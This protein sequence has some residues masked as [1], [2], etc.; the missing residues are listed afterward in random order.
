[1]RRLARQLSFAGALLL[2]GPGGAAAQGLP[3]GYDQGLFQVV[4]PRVGSAVVVVL[5]NPQGDVLLP[6]APVLELAS[7]PFAADEG[8]ALFRVPGPAGSDTA[9]LD[10]TRRQ[11]TRPGAADLA[12]GP[13][14]ARMHDGEPYVATRVLRELLRAQVT[15]EW[16]H[17]QVALTRDPPFPAQR[18][19]ELELQR[20]LAEVRARGHGAELPDA[21]L[22][23]RTGGGVLSWSLS[24]RHLD[25]LKASNLFGQAGVAVLGGRAT[26]GL[27]ASTSY[28]GGTG[29]EQ[30]TAAYERVFPGERWLSR[31]AVGDVVS[32]GVVARSLRGVSLTNAP[33]TRTPQF[34][35]ILVQPDL[36][37]GWQFEVYQEGRLVGFSDPAAPA[38][39]PVALSYGTTPLEVRM[40]GP[41]GEEVVSDLLYQIPTEHLQDGQLLYAAGGGACP[42][43]RCDALGYGALDYGVTRW[44]TL[45]T[46]GEYLREDGEGALRLSARGSIAP[47]GHWMGEFQALQGSF[48]QGSVRWSGSRRASGALSAALRS[49]GF[50]QPTF[51]PGPD[52]RWDVNAS[53]RL[54]PVSGNLRVAGPRGAR[55]DQWRVGLS[56]PIPR[57]Y[58]QGAFEAIRPADP[59]LEDLDLV[60]LRTFT[61][62][63][64]RWRR[65]PTLN[66]ALRAAAEGL[67]GAELGLSM[68]LGSG[69]A[70]VNGRWQTELGASLAVSFTRSVPWGRFQGVASAS[71]DEVL[72]AG[73]TLDGGLALDPRSPGSP[74]PA[75]SFGIGF[76]GV[77]GHVF[78]D[79]DGDGRFGAG[80][81]PAA[82]IQV[83]VAGRTGRTDARGMYQ[84][85]AV[86]PYD[87]VAVSVDTVAS[88]LPTWAPSTS[89]H[90]LRPVPHVF[91]DADFPLVRTRE[92]IGEVVAGP[93][94]LTSGGVTLELVHLD[95][96]ERREVLT[97]ED[98]Q[99][100]VSRLQVGGYE[101][102]V[103]P[104]SLR[105]L[106]ARA[107]PGTV[108]FRV[109]GRGE[110]P[111]V[112][113]ETVRLE[114]A[115]AGR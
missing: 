33:F 28:A 12:L 26:V 1:M 100:Y 66:A 39:V 37:A 101:L 38:P 68:P 60:S 25:P 79:Y 23:S 57:G 71:G 50:G 6:L 14:D 84:I 3:S 48:L 41:A 8:G 99:F 109:E 73:Y 103:A 58:L 5:V 78:Y 47:Q 61:L 17:L 46:G 13:D 36:P 49:P 35:Q 113:V 70:S 11:L 24:S 111:F 83:R 27:V 114:R 52:S 85:W 45:G 104:A 105:A 96:G 92:L 2:A 29:L 91:N 9:L 4:I 40:Y 54:S 62:L 19:A 53:G 21:P 82:D 20:R 31:V 86:P 30:V 77:R 63:P 55:P 112:E 81:E 51:L 43:A 72:R 64:G 44:L 67:H 106:G 42:T 98:G 69:H 90:V 94:V 115:E 10:F 34:D 89:R 107:V 80:D 108:R 76:A 87:P 15:V 22:A 88:F 74:V 95:T 56:R 7:V 102:R 16:P 59:A 110:D 97:F 93:G 75:G 65:Q 32:D 18:Q